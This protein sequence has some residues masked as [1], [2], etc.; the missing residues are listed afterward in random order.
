[1]SDNELWISF[2]LCDSAFPGG[3]LANS[4]GLESAVHHGLVER[5]NSESVMLFLSLSIEQVYPSIFRKFRL[6]RCIG[7]RTP[8]AVLKNCS[9]ISGCCRFQAILFA[10]RFLFPRCSYQ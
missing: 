10:I 3:C 6:R 9:S 4:Q 1:M 5:N 2:Q 7:D 8:V